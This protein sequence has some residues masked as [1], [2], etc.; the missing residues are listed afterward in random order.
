[1]WFPT[2]LSAYPQL[3]LMAVLVVIR[4]LRTNEFDFVVSMICCFA[5]PFCIH[6]CHVHV[7]TC[8]DTE[9]SDYYVAKSG[10]IPIRWTAPEALAGR[11]FSEFSDVW[12]YGITCIEVFTDAATPYKGWMNAFVFEQVRAQLLLFCFKTM[13]WLACCT[14]DGEMFCF[15]MHL[16]R[17]RCIVIHSPSLFFVWN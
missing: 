2:C 11:K 7:N 10:K 3:S 14:Q 12:A 15:Y 17:V 9:D 16:T 4:L 1:M 13:V 6:L 8:S 5:S